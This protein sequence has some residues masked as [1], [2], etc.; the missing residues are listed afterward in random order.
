MDSFLRLVQILSTAQYVPEAVS[1]DPWQ[2]RLLQSSLGAWVG[3]RHTLV[4]VSEEG[5][6]ECDFRIDRFE[7][8]E[9]EPAR[10]AVDP[11][12]AAWRQVALLLDA[13]RAHATRHAATKGLA[14]KMPGWTPT[15]HLAEARF[16]NTP[17]MKTAVMGGAM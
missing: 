13:L 14:E 16:Q 12:P 17:Q 1:K 6:A 3:L 2:R 8:L 5:S 9:L 4:L 7:K 11:F 15:L 10:G